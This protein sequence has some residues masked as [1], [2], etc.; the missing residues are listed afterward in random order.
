[1]KKDIQL[2]EVFEKLKEMLSTMSFGSVT[3]IVQ[4]GKIIQL[5]KNEKMRFK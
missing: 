3:L 2:E 5:E 4:D 1:M